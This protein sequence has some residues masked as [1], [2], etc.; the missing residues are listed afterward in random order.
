MQLESLTTSSMTRGILL[1]LS[2]V[3]AKPV[4]VCVT[5]AD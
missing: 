4:L 3:G 1:L 2:L 5:G